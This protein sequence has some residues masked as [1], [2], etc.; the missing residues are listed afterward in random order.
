MGRGDMGGHADASEAAADPMVGLGAETAVQ[1]CPILSCPTRW[2]DLLTCP[3]K[4][5]DGSYPQGGDE[6]WARLIPIG[7]SNSW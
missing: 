1:S 4:S 6:A 3:E 2:P 5:L 7:E